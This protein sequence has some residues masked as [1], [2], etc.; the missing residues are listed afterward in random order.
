MTG[1]HLPSNFEAR[2]NDV[3]L[4]ESEWKE[5]YKGAA[6]NPKD[7]WPIILHQLGIKLQKKPADWGVEKKEEEEDP[8]ADKKEDDN[9]KSPKK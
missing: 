8:D 2:V 1:S 3:H 5:F 6:L 9:K 7:T 4:S